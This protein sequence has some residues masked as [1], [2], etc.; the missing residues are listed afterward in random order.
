MILRTVRGIPLPEAPGH[1][2]LVALGGRL[3]IE[4][5]LGFKPG[6]VFASPEAV[7]SAIMCCLLVLPTLDRRLSTPWKALFC[8]LI[9]VFSLP[10]LQT[11]L[12]VWFGTTLVGP[13][14]VGIVA[15]WLR[16]TLSPF[17]PLVLSIYFAFRGTRYRGLHWVGVASWLAW[18]LI[19][20]VFVN[21]LL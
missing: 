2:L 14:H 13:A 20:P 19:Q 9:L 10:L 16:I 21:R 5:A 6:E 11:C 7:V 12:S 18:H 1:W 4:V 3:A 8:L 15:K 17:G